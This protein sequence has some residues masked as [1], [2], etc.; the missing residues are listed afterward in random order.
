MGNKQSAAGNQVSAV[1]LGD[2]AV[3]V[4]SFFSLSLEWDHLL[5]GPAFADLRPM[6]TENPGKSAL[7]VRFVEEKF[8]EAYN[9]TYESPFCCLPSFFNW[10]F[11]PGCPSPKL[12]DHPARLHRPDCILTL[13][14]Q[15]R[16]QLPQ[17]VFD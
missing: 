11:C 8:E 3:G 6:L 4:S 9:P 1:M 5:H 14:G 15:C 12:A 16:R 7:T 2:G 13:R 17:N 10:L